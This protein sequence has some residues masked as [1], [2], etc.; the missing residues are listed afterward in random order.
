MFARVFF[1]EE[2]DSEPVSQVSIETSQIYSY[3]HSKECDGVSTASTEDELC[4]YFR[5]LCEHWGLYVISGHCFEGN[6]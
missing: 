1:L 2:A 6:Y 5:S 3:G 4:T